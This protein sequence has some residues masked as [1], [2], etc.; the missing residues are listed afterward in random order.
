[1]SSEGAVLGIIFAAAA[2]DQETGF[3]VT[4]GAATKVADAGRSATNAT[5]TGEC[6]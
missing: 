5:S 2:D 6:A 1:M 4:A 3:A